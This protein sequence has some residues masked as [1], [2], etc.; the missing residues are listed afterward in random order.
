VEKELEELMD[1]IEGASG[2]PQRLEWNKQRTMVRVI[3]FEEKEQADTYVVLDWMEPN[4]L[5]G[6]L[7]VACKLFGA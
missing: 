2:L 6:E 7:T 5:R 3:G 1:R 4:Y